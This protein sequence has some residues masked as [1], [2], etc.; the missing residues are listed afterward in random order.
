M[1][2]R[3][4]KHGFA[5]LAI[6]DHIVVPT[7]ISSRYPYSESG[8]FPGAASGDALELFTVM[9][10]LAAV[11]TRIKLLSSI[12]VVPHRGAVHSAKILATIDQLS[13]GR[14]TVGVGAGWLEEEF[15]V[16]GAPPFAERGKVTDEYLAAFKELWTE[17]QPRFDG[18][19]VQ[20]SD[21]SFL[22]K[23]LQSPHPPIWVGGESEPALRRVI[24]HGDAWYPVGS[25]P[26]YPLNTR[27]RYV[28]AVK[29]LHQLA[30]SAG[31]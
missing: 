7:I 31:A 17:D 21:V 10:Y 28:G 29:R 5:Y 27:E 14:L 22:P 6:P 23:P 15:E 24:R 3:G 8:S 25:N 9:A 19:Y 11:T 18:K 16:I 30:R 1:A 20:F 13:G 26:R 2:K 12:M 4:E